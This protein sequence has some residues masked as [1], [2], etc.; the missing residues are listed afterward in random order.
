MVMPPGPCGR[1]GSL[2]V[3][4]WTPPNDLAMKQTGWS[5][6]EMAHLIVGDEEARPMMVGVSE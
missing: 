1:S 5:R 4:R 3:L 6:P 2:V